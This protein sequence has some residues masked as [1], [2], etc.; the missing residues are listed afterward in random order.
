MCKMG[1]NS[2]N[3]ALEKIEKLKMGVYENNE[4][5]KKELEHIY[6]SSEWRSARLNAFEILYRYDQH[7]R[8]DKYNYERGKNIALWSAELYSKIKDLDNDL[9]LAHTEN[10][11]KL[12]E[13][14]GSPDGISSEYI[15]KVYKKCPS[16]EARKMAGKALGYPRPWK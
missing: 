3:E 16:K 14:S 6:N 1:K 2:I 5:A 4:N 7:D 9:S 12:N 11:I 13:L 8:P 10:L 15:K